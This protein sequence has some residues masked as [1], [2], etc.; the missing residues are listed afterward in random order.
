MLSKRLKSIAGLIKETDNVLDIGCDHALLGVYLVKNKI[1]D[2]IIVS[3]ISEK[4]LENGLKNIKKYKVQDKIDARLGSGLEVADVH[5]D[6]V[7]I[8]GLGT[9]NILKMLNHPKTKKLKKL[10]IQSNNDHYLLR[11]VLTLRGFYISHESLVYEKGHYY[12]NI[13]FERGKRKYTRKELIYG[14][15]LMFANKDYYN[16]L[17]KKKK[18]IIDNIPKYKIF[19]ILKH[20][21]D[22]LFLKKLTK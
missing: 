16:F 12:I 4:A 9:T 3:D 7:V 22:E 2:H 11:R 10:I 13:V 8:T 19:T 15:F 18:A 5:V 20:K 1:L 6:T 21:K 14:P 17:L